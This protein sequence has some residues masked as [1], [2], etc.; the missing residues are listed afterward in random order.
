VGVEDA[1]EL[2]VE[3]LDGEETKLVEEAADL[4]AIVGV[5]GTTPASRSR[6]IWSANPLVG[7]SG[8]GGLL[9]G[10]ACDV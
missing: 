3:V 4:D 9:S 5:W 6:L 10:G 1:L 8:L 2:A 7:G